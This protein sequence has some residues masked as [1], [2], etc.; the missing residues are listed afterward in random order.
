M[1]NIIFNNNKITPSKVVCIGKNYLDHIKELKGEIPSNIVIF[2]KPNSSVSSDLY[3][4]ETSECHHEAEVSFLIMNNQI[5]AVAFGLDLTKRAIQRELKSKGL[6]WERAK[7]FDKS[8]VFSEFID[9]SENDIKNI[10]IELYINGNLKQ[11]GHYNQMINKPQKLLSEI[12][13]FMTMENG[14]ILMTGTP[15][16]VGEFKKGDIF[17]GRILLNEKVVIEKEWVVK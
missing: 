5:K 1:N 17:L 15:K 12:K 7:A 3:H 9:I 4:F 6:P 11:K 10:G 16:G 13:S 2:N 8:A 14:D